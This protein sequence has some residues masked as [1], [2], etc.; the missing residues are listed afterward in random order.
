M[1][2]RKTDRIAL[3]FIFLII[4]MAGCCRST[5]NCCNSAYQIR[6]KDLKTGTQLR[7]FLVRYQKPEECYK[8]ITQRIRLGD[9]QGSLILGQFYL[10]VWP[11]EK[12]SA[13]V[14]NLILI[15]SLLRISSG[16]KPD[17][18]SVYISNSFVQETIDIMNELVKSHDNSDII[19]W[20]RLLNQGSVHTRPFFDFLQ[21]SRLYF[22]DNMPKHQ[23]IFNR[24][25]NNHRE[26]CE[27]FRAFEILDTFK[28][29]IPNTRTS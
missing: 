14:I 22:F 12:A 16:D 6:V 2:K 24:L 9:Y 29:L 23:Q 11:S 19:L 1:E 5:Y 28:K 15:S 26:W 7:S 10:K 17:L 21:S 20:N 13:D 27:Q 4:I 8:D 3:Y 25:R 18:N